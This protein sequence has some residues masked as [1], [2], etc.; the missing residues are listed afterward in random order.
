MLFVGSQCHLIHSL[1]YVFGAYPRFVLRKAVYRLKVHWK[2]QTLG[3][4]LESE[5]LEAFHRSW[6]TLGLKSTQRIP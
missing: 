6:L 5:V 1:I 2:L 3:L 4:S